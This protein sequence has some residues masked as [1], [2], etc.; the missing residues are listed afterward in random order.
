ME[1]ELRSYLYLE[2]ISQMQQNSMNDKRFTR[3]M[4]VPF[5]MKMSDFVEWRAPFLSSH[6]KW[7]TTSYQS[8]REREGR[9]QTID[10]HKGCMSEN[11]FCIFYVTVV[12]ATFS[13][14]LQLYYILLLLCK[15]KLMR[16]RMVFSSQQC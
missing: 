5:C 7:L 11:I 10:T 2:S 3:F 6:K 4:F 9:W 1:I 12:I 8:K 15:A 13:I 16:Q 14:L